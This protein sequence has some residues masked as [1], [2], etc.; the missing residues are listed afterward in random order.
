MLGI[1]CFVSSQYHA[2]EKYRMAKVT[3]SVKAINL[4]KCFGEINS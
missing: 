2:L 1:L 4:A 3:D